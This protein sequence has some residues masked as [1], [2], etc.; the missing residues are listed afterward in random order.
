MYPVEPVK[1][2]KPNCDDA[3]LN[4]LL[5]WRFWFQSHRSDLGK[6]NQIWISRNMTVV[7]NFW[8][9]LRHSS[10]NIL[11]S[12]NKHKILLFWHFPNVVCLFVMSILLKLNQNC[13]LNKIL[14]NVLKASTKK[15]ITFRKW[16]TRGILW[17]FRILL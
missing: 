3:P 12:Q 2:I 7:C 5:R 16:Q 11:H 10:V 13:R 8:N 6:P 14:L 4:C 1:E 15:Q 9:Y 17:Y